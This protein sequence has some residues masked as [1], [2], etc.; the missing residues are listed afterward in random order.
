MNKHIYIFVHSSQTKKRELQK[1]AEI[2]VFDAMQIN[3]CFKFHST[4]RAVE[5]QSSWD[6]RSVHCPNRYL[7]SEQL[8]K[9]EDVLSKE[10]RQSE[11]KSELSVL[12]RGLVG[13]FGA[14]QEAKT[15]LTAKK[16][17]QIK[18]HF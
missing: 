15:C 6:Q 8:S 2:F 17:I 4:A 18:R 10:R 1:K 12:L 16:V 3:L 9:V 14:T 13:K 7:M 5:C 11:E